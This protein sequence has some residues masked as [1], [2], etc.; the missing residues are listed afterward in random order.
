MN[1]LPTS[2]YLFSVTAF[3]AIGAW[4]HTAHIRAIGTNDY[5]KE[6]RNKYNLNHDEAEERARLQ[7][8][9]DIVLTVVCGAL[10]L[11]FMFQTIYNLVKQA[12]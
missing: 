9:A 11:F 3:L 6:L 5:I 1:Q 2:V 10:A 12:A 8:I 7:L 4:L